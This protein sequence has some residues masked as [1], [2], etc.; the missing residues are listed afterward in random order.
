M[1][2]AR[3]SVGTENQDAQWQWLLRAFQW[4]Q[5]RSK[6]E[7]RSQIVSLQRALGSVEIP[8]FLF[9]VILERTDEKKGKF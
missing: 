7:G 1:D 9:L 3:I 4:K 8:I 5:N 6:G 2:E